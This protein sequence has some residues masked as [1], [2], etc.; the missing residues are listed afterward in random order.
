MSFHFA[1]RQTLVKRSYIKS[2]LCFCATGVGPM[3]FP[4]CKR[5][6]FP[7][8]PSRTVATCNVF[9]VSI[10]HVEP[11]KPSLQMVQNV[12]CRWWWGTHYSPSEIRTLKNWRS[13]KSLGCGTAHQLLPR[14]PTSEIHGLSW[15]PLSHAPP[16]VQRSSTTSPRVW[17]GC[18]W[19]GL[20]AIDIAR[21]TVTPPVTRGRDTHTHTKCLF[22]QWC[23][24]SF[25]FFEW[26][27]WFKFNNLC[28]NILCWKFGE[29]D[30]HQW[31][32]ILQIVI[33][34]TSIFS[35]NVPV[36]ILLC[37]FIDKELLKL[38]QPCQYDQA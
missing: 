18:H 23:T 3:C 28:Q 13:K 14:S 12:L 16:G 8:P 37:V 10:H 7:A 6:W 22:F 31:C 4:I 2:C 27:E 1:H 17:R 38:S 19:G 25:L 9:G 26:L 33:G 35:K 20:L 30:V 34:C 15:K 29:V 11:L 36:P 32:S 24:D 21:G 5:Y